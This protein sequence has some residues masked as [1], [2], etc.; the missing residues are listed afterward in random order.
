MIQLE[1]RDVDDGSRGSAS[2]GMN[3]YQAVP[4][5]QSMSAMAVEVRR[6][7]T[8]VGGSALGTFCLQGDSPHSTPK[9]KWGRG[10][11]STPFRPFAALQRLAESGHQGATLRAFLLLLAERPLS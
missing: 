2:L 3:Q 10:P 11:V 9:A 8:I 5:G 1:I 4:C 7:G 6:S